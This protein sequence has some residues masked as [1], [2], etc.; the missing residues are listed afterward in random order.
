M[1][2]NKKILEE[3]ARIRLLM[4]GRAD[5]LKWITSKIIG[6]G[7]DEVFNLF[8]KPD[9]ETRKIINNLSNAT[10]DDISKIF[11]KMDPVRLGEMLFNKGILFSSNSIVSNIDKIL[12]ALGEAKTKDQRFE[13]YKTY[14][15]YISEMDLSSFLPP[16]SLDEKWFSEIMDEAFSEWKSLFLQRIARTIE[17][18]QPKIH[19]ELMAK[20]GKREYLF[21]A[22]KVPMEFWYWMDKQWYNVFNK[23][24]GTLRRAFASI[25][26]SKATLQKEF[27]LEMERAIQRINQGKNPRPHIQ[28]ASDKLISANFWGNDIESLRKIFINELDE[29]AKREFRSNNWGE[30]QIDDYIDQ[31][32]K[33]DPI[34]EKIWESIGRYYDLVPP[35]LCRRRGTCVKDWKLWARRW[36]QMIL[37]LN[38]LTAA[39]LKKDII[40]RGF[41]P[42]GA[43]YLAN[44]AIGRF[45]IAPGL[46]ATAATLKEIGKAAVNP[47]ENLNDMGI[48][49]LD[50][51]WLE[52]YAEYDVEELSLY[53]LTGLDDVKRLYQ[54]LNETEAPKIDLDPELARIMGNCADQIRI[55][56]VTNAEVLTALTASGRIPITLYWGEQPTGWPDNKKYT[57]FKDKNGVYKW[58]GEDNKFYPLEDVVKGA[59]CQ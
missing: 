19:M 58:V 34:W 8:N 51:L 39:E 50:E 9:D 30:K 46:Y 48:K 20:V 27:V 12:K 3:I 40:N 5:A 59:N 57:I 38:P 29:Q 49:Y 36:M 42:T 6:L 25:I 52:K 53:Q 7:S 33:D 13:I 56:T 45:F 24:A 10:D 23:E 17:E 15:D 1:K 11:S 32:V 21:G 44:W 18:R 28:L 4:E 31:A 54:K 43:I 14:A 2:K 37:K 41:L 16:G 26:T 35:T 55:Y 22:V 47:N